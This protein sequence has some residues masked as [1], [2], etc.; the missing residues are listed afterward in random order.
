MRRYVVITGLIAAFA[1]A[2]F[3]SNWT[4]VASFD[5]PYPSSGYG[6]EAYGNYLYCIAGPPA[7]RLDIITTTGSLIGTMPLIYAGY[8]LDFD[9]TYFWVVQTDHQCRRYTSSGS[10]LGSFSIGS[11][12]GDGIAWDGTYIWLKGNV[13]TEYIYRM[14]TTGSIYSSF[15]CPADGNAALDWSANYLWN[16]SRV[17][18]V[19]Y[20]TTT[21]GSIVDTFTGPASW[22]YGAS[23][24]GTYFW[25]TNQANGWVYKMQDVEAIAPSSLGRVKALYR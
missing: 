7:S 13:A 5:G 12:N 10:T 23:W 25:T 3:A 18:S 1:A 19:I 24:D 8:D 15:A 20:K 17:A 9:G 14:S 2:C 11:I 16:P 4:V 21:T 22:C 6:I